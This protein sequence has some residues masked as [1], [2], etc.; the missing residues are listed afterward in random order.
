MLNLSNEINWEL[1]ENAKYVIVEASNED[2]GFTVSVDGI[3]AIDMNEETLKEAIKSETV[4][5]ITENWEATQDVKTF[6]LSMVEYSLE[7]NVDDS[8]ENDLYKHEVVYEDNDGK[9]YSLINVVN[10]GEYNVSE[11]KSYIR[12]IESNI[13]NN[14]QWAYEYLVAKSDLN[15]VLGV[16]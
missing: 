4:E 8:G 2:E 6:A 1:L 5:V 11:D 13:S 12:I 16:E 7:I 14:I 9:Y 3:Y 10:E 15:K